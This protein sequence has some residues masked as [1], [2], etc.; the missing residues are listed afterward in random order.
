MATLEKI[1]KR[2]VF[3]TVFIGAAL[4]AFIGEEA[5]RASGSL[6]NDTVAARVG[7]QSVGVE[8]FNK[9]YEEM[10]QQ[11]EK[12]PNKQDAAIQQ[13]QLLAQMEIETI[14][15]QEYKENGID[16]S[17][18]EMT[19]LLNQNQ[20]AMQMTQYL[21]QQLQ[22]NIQSPAQLDKLIQAD[23]QRFALVSAQWNEMK[24]Q[25][26]NSLRQYKLYYLVSN[27]IQPNDLDRLA[28][29]EENGDTYTVEF[30][31]KDF[32]DL[33]ADKKYEPSKS[34]IQA[35]YDEYK[36]LWKLNDPQ[37]RIHYIAYNIVPSAKDLDAGHKAVA[38]AEALI[39]GPQGLDSIRTV[40]EFSN[41]Q[42]NKITAEQAKQIGTQ[43][44]DSAFAAFVSGGKVGSWHKYNSGNDYAFFKIS[45]IAQLTDTAKVVIVAAQGDKKQQD[46]VFAALNAGQDV[47][48]IKGVEVQPEQALQLQNPQLNLGDSVKNLIENTAVGKYFVVTTDPKAGAV[49]MKV[50]SKVKKTFYTIGTS[51]YTIEAST[52]T[53]N[54]DQDKL[55]N[56]LNRNKTAAAFAKNAVKAGFTPR[57]AVV[58]SST[59]QLQDPATGRGIENSRKA[60]KWALTEGKPGEVSAIFSDNHDVLIAVALDNLYKDEYMPLSA[61]EVQKFCANKARM[62]KIADALTKQYKNQAKDVSGYALKFGTKA[63]TT[64]VIFGSDQMMKV[65]TMPLSGDGSEG[66]GGFIGR[67]AGSKIG[68]VYF[69]TGNSA[70]YAFK[71]IKKDVSKMKLKKEELD[72]RWMMQYGIYE[73][74][75]M[76]VSRFSAV[77]LNSEKIKNNLVKFM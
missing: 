14:L 31:K 9:R 16:V 71:V 13:Q 20:Q 68:Q 26:Y 58:S 62:R 28:M 48:K 17:G 19:M 3:L 73:N 24:H 42:T 45:A 70:V 59:P 34:E 21:A 12:N 15:D 57:E 61:P 55:Q 51:N 29:E 77:L 74:P 64:Q 7:S 4:L 56:F 30:A 11:N 75:Q 65:N 1:R 27:A 38:K 35:V 49:F 43:M 40:S 50:N 8:A 44:G 63:D 33:A 2:T 66:D 6:F 72:N 69:W 10:S 25:A 54:G 41:V 47:S 53:S 23:P 22:Q 76:G 67:V 36:Q 52:A 39:Q 32:A 37:A 60:I 5:V 46:K 18:E